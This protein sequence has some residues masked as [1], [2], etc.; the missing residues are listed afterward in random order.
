MKRHSYINIISILILLSLLGFG[1]TL[2]L[3]TVSEYVVTRTDDVAA[4]L[5]AVGNCS[6][7]QAIT[8]SNVC[9]GQ[10]DVRIPVGTYILTRTG[11]G[12]NSNARGDLDI[13]DSVNII[14]TGMPVIDG[15][16]TDRVFDIQPGAVVGMSGLV[17]QNGQYE[18]VELGEGGGIQNKGNLTATGLLI[19]NN[20]GRGA[21]SN[22]GGGLSNKDGATAVISHSAIISNFSEEGAGGILNYGNMTLDNVTISG[23]DA[24]GIFTA[25]GHLEISY[26]TITNNHPYQIQSSG[27]AVVISNSI[28]S[29]STDWSSCRGAFISNGF[30]IEYYSAGTD[31]RDNCNFTQSS[32]LVN[33][34]PVLLPLSTYDG[35]TLPFHELDPASPAIDSADPA[36][37]SGTDQRGVARPQGAACDRGAYE[38][39]EGIPTPDVP[40][41]TAPPEVG[42]P[43]LIQYILV[44][45][46]PANCR[47]GPGVEYPVVNSAQP[48]AQVQVIGKSMD[49]AWWYSQIANDKCF[50]SNIAGTPSGDLTK[51]SII[52]DPP[53]PVPTSTPKPEKVE[54][55]DKPTNQVIVEIDYDGDGY[56][57][58]KDC[59]DKNAKINPGAVETPN[60]KVDSNCN[61]DDNK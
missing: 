61:G 26:S 57:A 17:V 60:D 58:S 16:A 29:G 25:V 34:D 9:P 52:P 36:H 30:N 46:V 15:N 42:A 31:P 39:H 21:G 6:L 2:P 20:V 44:V 35:T 3:C 8:A 49:G 12:E 45:Q 4:G 19:R 23:N 48:G 22:G 40:P 28:I 59:N 37:C 55:T 38:W 51:L 41:A 50:I 10:Q 47:Q 56:P 14:G 24:Y 1:C 32:D 43:V 33:V 54:P 53:K 27:D 18:E 5:C 7:R 13:V 11:A